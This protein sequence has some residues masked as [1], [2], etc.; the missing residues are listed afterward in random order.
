MTKLSAFMKLIKVL[1]AGPVTVRQW[2]QMGI[3]GLGDLKRAA[4]GGRVRLTAMQRVGVQY[5]DVFQ[6]RIPRALVARIGRKIIKHLGQ[7]EIAGSYRRGAPSSLD[8]DIVT[9]AELL[10][11]PKITYITRGESKCMILYHLDNDVHPVIC[12]DIVRCKPAEYVTTLF[13]LTGSG[14]FNVMMR[15]RAADMGYR[16][17][18]HGLFHGGKRV[19]IASEK[20]L[21]KILKLEYIPPENR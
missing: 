17:S 7:G 12:V 14:L 16:L 8:I 20:E 4:T 13:Y 9:T 15:K 10:P 19:V 5:Y 11:H 2:L 3:R 1:G 18:E 6:L 21:F